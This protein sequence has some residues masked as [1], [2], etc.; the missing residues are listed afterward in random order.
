MNQFS[1]LKIIS[2]KLKDKMLHL[3]EKLK[4]MPN[5]KSNILSQNIGKVIR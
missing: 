4:Q 5:I 3:K 2:N 1:I